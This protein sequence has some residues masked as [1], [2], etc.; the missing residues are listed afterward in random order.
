M[1]V[2]VAKKGD[3]FRVVESSTGK[4]AKNRAGTAIDGGGFKSKIRATAQVRAVNRKKR[5]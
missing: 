4:I 5:P 2:R 1:P 3:K